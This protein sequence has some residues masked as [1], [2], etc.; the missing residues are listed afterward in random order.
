M[1]TMCHIRSVLK[2]LLLGF[3]CNIDNNVGKDDTNDDDDDK[4]SENDDD[5]DT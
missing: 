4:D 1:M 3:S 5:D 2:F